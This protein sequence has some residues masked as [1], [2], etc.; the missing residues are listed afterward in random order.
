MDDNILLKTLRELNVTLH[1]Q[2]NI[3][4]KYVNLK[5]AKL[6]LGDQT[7]FLQTAENFNDPFELHLGFIEPSGINDIIS[8]LRK[9]GLSQPG[10]EDELKMIGDETFREST[11]K[12]LLSCRSTYGIYCMSKINDSTLM[13]SHYADKHRGV[14]LG[15]KVP[16]MSGP[17]ITVEVKYEDEIK[18][19]QH[20]F[21]TS[22]TSVRWMCC[23]S[24]VW[25]YENEVR[26]IDVL[27]N[28]VFPFH[29]SNL[30]EIYFG[31][32]TPQEE[33]DALKAIIKQKDYPISNSGKMYINKYD[34]KLAIE[35]FNL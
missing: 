22:G 5:D 34:F 20:S 2:R 9:K 8:F 19:L 4:Y 27:N 1:D 23:K 6:I 26:L 30:C 21:E 10:L 16:T 31:V 35:E 29:K 14:C 33:I 3:L 15:F 24:K 13:W 12:A 17:T 11:T 32:T 28:G 7:I 18:P 25:E